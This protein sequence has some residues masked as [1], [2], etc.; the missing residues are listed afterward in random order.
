MVYLQFL[1]TSNSF[2]EAWPEKA[3]KNRPK[4]V[5]SSYWKISQQK[6][7]K[8]N[9]FYPLLITNTYVHK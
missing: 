6:Y 7:T 4:K 3:I 5:R 8:F 9:S 2:D 1:K